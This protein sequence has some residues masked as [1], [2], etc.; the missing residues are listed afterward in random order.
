[1][2]SRSKERKQKEEEMSSHTKENHKNV[3]NTTG[4]QK[5]NKKFSGQK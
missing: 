2:T 3:N 5:V 1:V 4:T